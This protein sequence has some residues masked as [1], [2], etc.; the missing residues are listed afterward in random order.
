M[1][2]RQAGQEARQD[3]Q[4]Q[5]E[6]VRPAQHAGIESSTAFAATIAPGRRCI[7]ALHARESLLQAGLV[8]S[9]LQARL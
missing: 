7:K 2:Q 6:V 4:V 3:L 5:A 9:M 8:T 1:P